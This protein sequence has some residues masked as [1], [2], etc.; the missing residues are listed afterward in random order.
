MLFHGD[1][2]AI[3]KMRH[4]WIM[5]LPTAQG[6]VSSDSTFETQDCSLLL[7]MSQAVR[8]I[9]ALA[10]SQEYKRQ[11]STTLKKAPHETP[12]LELD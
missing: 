11:P 1:A 12:D 8:L 9:D 10:S 3:Y 2:E 5:C 6:Q 7:F 4:P